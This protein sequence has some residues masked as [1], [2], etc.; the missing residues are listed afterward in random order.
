[1][2]RA[3]SL[4]RCLASQREGERDHRDSARHTNPEMHLA[5]AYGLHEVLDHRRPYGAGEIISGSGDRHCD[6]TPAREPVRNV[7]DDRTE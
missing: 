3:G 6:A 7:G 5:P 4:G 2:H 1:M